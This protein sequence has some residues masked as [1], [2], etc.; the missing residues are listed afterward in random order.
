L[1]HWTSPFFCWVFLKWGSPKLFAR[2]W[3]Q[4]GQ[5]SWSLN[6]VVS[7]QCPER[8]KFLILSPTANA[9]VIFL[10]EWENNFWFLDYD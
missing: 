8:A 6:T 4:T 9:S 7:H 3:L 5:S 1:N 10:T 2:G